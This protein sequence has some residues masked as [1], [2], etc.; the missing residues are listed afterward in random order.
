M[1]YFYYLKRKTIYNIALW[2]TTNGLEFLKF[3]PTG[4]GASLARG[5]R[6]NKSG[7]ILKTK[8]NL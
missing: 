7:K 1:H 5:W 6:R 4:F 8:D 2:Y 3:Y